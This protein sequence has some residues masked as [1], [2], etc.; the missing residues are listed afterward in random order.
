MK[1]I[2]F[3]GLL[4]PFYFLGALEFFFFFWGWGVLIVCPLG[5]RVLQFPQC[6]LILDP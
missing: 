4:H 5:M 2:D 1:K 3:L 6:L